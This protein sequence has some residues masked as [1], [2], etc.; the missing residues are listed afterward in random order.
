MKKMRTRERDRDRFDE[1]RKTRQKFCYFCKE[2]VG[3]I[4]YK[5]YS[6]LRRFTSEK[7][8][9]K[10]RRV[11]GTCGQHQRELAVAIRRARE[12]ALIPYSSR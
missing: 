6:T 11:T 4:D 5:D 9:I 2:K 12:M 7:N 3:F 10:A 1:P 8:K